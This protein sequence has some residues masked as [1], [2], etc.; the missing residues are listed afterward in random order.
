MALLRSLTTALTAMR[1]NLIWF[2]LA[3]YAVAAVWPERGSELARWSLGS[4]PFSGE[5]LRVTHLLLAVLLFC[6][7]IAIRS[8]DARNLW[9]F[10][11]TVTLGLIGGWLLPPMVLACCAWL[12]SAVVGGGEWDAFL[13]GA[14]LVVAMP[15]ANSSSIWSE[16]CGGQAAAIVTVIVLG[17][18]LTPLAAPLIVSLFT[19]LMGA[20]HLQIPLSTASL[21][22]VLFAFVML[23]VALGIVVR[24]LLDAAVPS[25]AAMLLHGARVVSLF[26]LLALNYVN[27]SV[28][29]PQVV[30]GARM[31]SAGIVAVLTAGFCSVVFFAAAAIGRRWPGGPPGNQLG[32]VYV[33]SMKNTGA[34]LVL[35]VSLFPEQPHV[36]LVPVLYTLTQHFAAALLDRLTCGPR[37]AKESIPAAS[38]PTTLAQTSTPS[39]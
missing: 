7:G 25:G 14:I 33:T 15:A 6:V 31:A 8:G 23:P 32:F 12:G 11:R 37:R 39:Y 27:A 16:L 34:A 13:I 3:T 22:E 9:R 21:L 30:S 2:L 36:A 24:A 38:L 17:T 10:S 4:L 19:T 26:A 28:A 5:G 1:R 35:A 29:L 20:D 18:L